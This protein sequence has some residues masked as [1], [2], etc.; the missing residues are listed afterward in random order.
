MASQK[1]ETV[2]NS[3]SSPESV[4]KLLGIFGTSPVLTG[5]LTP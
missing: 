5:E 4:N 3:K 1:Q 2:N